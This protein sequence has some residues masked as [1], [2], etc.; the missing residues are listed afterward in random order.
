[1]AVLALAFGVVNH[2]LFAAAIASM[3]TALWT[4]LGTGRGAWHGPPAAVANLLLVLQFPLLHS[5]LLGRHG[6]RWLSR[7]FPGDY[8]RT[9]VTT[10]Y[11]TTASL[12]LLLVFWLWSPSGIV[13]WRPA[14]WL[15]VVHG[16]VFAACWLLLSKAIIDSGIAL[17]SG[18]LGRWVVFRGRPPRY[19]AFAT[20]GTLALCRQPIYLAFASIL[21]TAPTWTPDRIL[22]AVAWTAYCVLG[23]RRKERRYLARHGDAYRR[24]QSRVAYF[25]PLRIRRP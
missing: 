6:R 17:Q 10:S 9:L 5:A 19:P 7:V 20:A 23:P 18:A 21:W 24:Y 4:G 3:A 11:A 13:V 2:V 16:G 22:L 1:V 15:L 12:Q 25:L 14:G 8:G